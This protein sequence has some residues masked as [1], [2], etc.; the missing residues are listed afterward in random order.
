MYSYSRIRIVIADDHEIFRDGFK[1]MLQKLAEKEI[2]IVGEA[3]NG[4]QLL[5]EVEKHNPDVVVTDIRMPLMNGLEATKLL[6][7]NFS[8]IP[9]IALTMF[10]EDS[11]I[12]SMVE[13]GARG[14]LLKNTNSEEIVRAI[15][16]VNS[17]EIYYSNTTS[18]K[19]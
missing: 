2:E 7:Q 19:L 12:Y 6:R 16:I 17:G 8:C 3:S 18:R 9:V 1:T 11:L 4:K 10:D 14:Y 15:Q 13:A 5:Q